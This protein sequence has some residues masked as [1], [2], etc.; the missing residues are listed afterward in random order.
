HAHK[1]GQYPEVAQVVRIGAKGGENPAYVRALKGVRY[2]HAEE[3]EAQVRQLA[4]AEVTLAVHGNMRFKG[5]GP[6]P[7][8]SPVNLRLQM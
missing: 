3:A 2:L 1:G 7:S 6:A 5:Q 8:A 4:E